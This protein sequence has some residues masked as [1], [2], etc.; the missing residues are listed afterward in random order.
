MT[1][2]G[3]V[4]RALPWPVFF[5]ALAVWGAEPETGGR[6]SAP[7]EIPESQPVGARAGD[8][9]ILGPD[10]TGVRQMS[11]IA[12]ALL[13]R[14]RRSVPSATLTGGPVIFV[15]LNAPDNHPHEAPFVISAHADGQVTCHVRW[16]ERLT[17]GLAERALAQALFTRLSVMQTGG[18]SVHVP[19]WVEMA[20][21]HLTRNQGIS[22][23]TLHLRDVLRETRIWRIEEILTQERGVEFGLDFEANAFWLFLFLER[24]GRERGLLDNFLVRLSRGQAPGS[25]LSAVYGGRFLHS[26]EIEMWWMVGVH[27]LIE[28]PRSPVL[29]ADRSLRRLEALAMVTVKPGGEGERRLTVADL[30]AARERGSLQRELERRL[31]LMGIESDSI[32]PF[33]HNGHLSLGQAFQAVLDGDEE[34]YLR[35]REAWL[36]DIDAGRRLMRETTSV[37]EELCPWRSR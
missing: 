34:A 24:E 33:F 19:L 21:L 5:L 22:T 30:W 20:A 27:D 37:L 10:F 9:E 1:L 25:A 17:R 4:R 26:D 23:H 6:E 11:A 36:F 31:I 13:N 8:F 12:D 7:T 35:A 28:Q 32:H 2:A 14:M 18:R 3:T 16:D 15:S 29:P